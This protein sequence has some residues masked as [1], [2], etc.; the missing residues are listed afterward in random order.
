MSNLERAQEGLSSDFLTTLRNK[1]HEHTLAK[2]ATYFAEDGT[3]YTQNNPALKKGE[4][5]V[6]YYDYQP[7]C[8]SV[9]GKLAAHGNEQALAI[10]RR[11]FDN[12][13]YYIG[14]GR[15]KEGF[16][17]SLRRSQLHLVLCYEHLKPVLEQSE[18]QAWAELLT[19]TC[20]DMLDHFKALQ[21]R[22]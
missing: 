20:E 3:A 15:E 1:I 16:T 12:V 14:E 11:L 9:L 7:C 17:V 4:M 13:R 21:E 22:V 18:T 19:Q 6:N 8:A 5:V 10:V 2:A